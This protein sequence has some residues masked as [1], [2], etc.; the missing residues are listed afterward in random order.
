MSWQ[1][2]LQQLDSALAEG[3]ISAD[4]YR[5]RRDEVLAQASAAQPAAP[6]QPPSGPF[7][8]PFRWAPPTPD[9]TQVMPTIKDSPGSAE[10]DRTQVVPNAGPAARPAGGQEADRTQ[11]VSSSAGQAAHAGGQ[12]EADRTQVVSSPGQQQQQQY[13]AQAYGQPSQPGWQQQQQDVA[14]PWAGTDMPA[15]DTSWGMRQG[16]EVFDDKPGGNKAG[17]VIGIVLA[18]VVLAGLGFGGYML[19]GKGSGG[20]DVAAST[21]TTTTTKTTPPKPKVPPGPFVEVPGGTSQFNAVSIANALQAKVPTLEEATLLQNNGVT[22]VRFVLSQDTDLNQGIWGFV[23]S[24]GTDPAAVLNAIDQLYNSAKYQLLPG[25]PPNVLVRYL[26]A[27]DHNKTPTYR[28]HYVT[29]GMVIRVEAYGTDDAT[30][31]AAFDALLKRETDK[32]APGA[33]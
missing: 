10:A 20:G 17:K 28:A 8:P 32:F 18:I 13:P 16:P 11:V 22:E 3:R 14:P 26:P 29:G 9:S 4:D 25:G 24:T 27:S 7:P 5:R 19:W 33:R 21:T 12:Q 31:K 15:L 6:A 23:P 2:E 1:E 30:A